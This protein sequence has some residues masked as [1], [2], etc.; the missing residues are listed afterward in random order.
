MEIIEDT[1]CKYCEDITA[2]CLCAIVTENY[3]IL[4][5]F[6][7][8]NFDFNLNLFEIYNNS[9]NEL[10]EYIGINAFDISIKIRC[11]SIC[12]YFIDRIKPIT[13]SNILINYFC[14]VFHPYDKK[15]INEFMILYSNKINVDLNKFFDQLLI[16]FFNYCNPEPSALNLLLSYGPDLNIFDQ[17][18]I[19]NII[20]MCQPWIL[21]KLICHGLNLHQDYISIIAEYWNNPF[22]IEKIDILLRHGL[23]LTENDIYKLL[24][25][26]YHCVKRLQKCSELFIK[27]SIDLSNIKIEYYDSEMINGLCDLG[28]D[29][30]QVA[31]YLLQ[32]K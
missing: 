10:T 23:I 16:I 24:C 2:I 17:L 12:N 15:F 26:G 29:E 7:E 27:Y 5:I 11:I 13:D 6:I 1:K 4:N 25:S 21:E 3:N 19:K 20:K 30:S 32:K 14:Q 28:F 31:R 9:E 18:M 8:Y 22:C